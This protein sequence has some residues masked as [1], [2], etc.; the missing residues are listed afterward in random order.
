MLKS[1]VKFC[2]PALYFQQTEKDMFRCVQET[3]CCISLGLL[4]LFTGVEVALNEELCTSWT[5][6]GDY[7]RMREVSVTW[8]NRTERKMVL[9]TP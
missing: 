9:W 6:W 5:F 2:L 7:N 4:C 3:V 1:N 8:Q